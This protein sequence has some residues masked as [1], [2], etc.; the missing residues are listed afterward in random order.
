MP[1][2]YRGGIVAHDGRTGANPRRPVYPACTAVRQ[3][4]LTWDCLVTSSPLRKS[5]RPR[6]PVPCGVPSDC[7][8]DLD[9][10]RWPLVRTAV[11]GAH[12]LGT[13]VPRM[14]APS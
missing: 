1:W 10:W 14:R 3:R 2:P 5:L 12:E 13:E 4:L 9:P 11:R 8:Y 6:G 7:T